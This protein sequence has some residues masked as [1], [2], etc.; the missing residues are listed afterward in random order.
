[1]AGISSLRQALALKAKHLHPMHT[2]V[3]QLRSELLSALLVAGDMEAAPAVC[4]DVIDTYRVGYPAGHPMTGLQL[5]TLG[6]LYRALG[7]SGDAVG[8]LT[9]AEAVLSV[10][11]GRD[12][13]FV[14]KLVALLAETRA[15]AGST[16]S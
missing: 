2:Q 3:L 6:S 5:Y 10:T 14:Q 4:R 11:H 1:M 7:R 8:V 12:S 13:E 15:L 16:S 9:E